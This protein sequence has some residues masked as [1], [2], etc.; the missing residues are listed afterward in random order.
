MNEEKEPKFI[1]DG[2]KRFPKYEEIFP[3]DDG[4]FVLDASNIEAITNLATIVVNKHF[5]N[6]DEFDELVQVGIVNIV[7]KLNEG[8]F[9]KTKGSLKNYL[10][11]AARNGCTNYVYHFK[12][13]KKEVI[14]DTM[15]DGIHTHLDLP[16]VDSIVLKQF[17][18]KLH[19]AYLVPIDI[20]ANYLYQKGF[21]VSR[22]CLTQVDIVYSKYK[23]EKTFIK[24]IKYYKNL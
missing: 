7:D 21:P 13:N 9:D 6:Y 18:S 20:F 11:T 22:D 15:P 5:R 24:F 2:F 3:N 17:F 8:G 4:I 10:Y 1:T 16:I 23:L 14:A 12:N 19:K